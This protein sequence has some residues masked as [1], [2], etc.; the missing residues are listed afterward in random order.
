MVS[1]CVIRIALAKYV[2]L[3]GKLYQEGG[4]TLLIYVLRKVRD[5]LERGRLIGA[6]VYQKN[7]DLLKPLWVVGWGALQHA[8]PVL[9]L[10]RV[11]N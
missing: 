4:S 8:C 1:N 3:F 11:A 2:S 5:V 7:G 9:G 10:L 6:A